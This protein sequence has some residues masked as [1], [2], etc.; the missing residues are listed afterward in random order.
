MSQE[1]L[2]LNA[3]LTPCRKP[4]SRYTPSRMVVPHVCMAARMWTSCRACKRALCPHLVPSSTCE[5]R[6]PG[7]L[8]AAQRMIPRD[9]AMPVPERA[10]NAFHGGGRTTS[11]NKE[12]GGIIFCGVLMMYGDSYRA[13]FYGDAPPRRA[14]RLRASAISAAG[15]FIQ[16]HDAHQTTSCLA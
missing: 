16:F 1:N 12:A 13:R 15:Y 10:R 4:S 8:H 5:I 9:L 6:I 14:A 2:P 11:W 7:A 3:L